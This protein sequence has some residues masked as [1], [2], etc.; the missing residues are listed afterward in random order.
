MMGC[1]L[2]N[3]FIQFLGSYIYFYV[4]NKDLIEKKY[5]K[6]NLKVK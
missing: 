1:T 6:Y 4:N 3:E 5:K 2:K